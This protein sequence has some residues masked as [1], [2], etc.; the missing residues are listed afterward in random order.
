MTKPSAYP[1]V[2]FPPVA[3]PKTI[4]D[5]HSTVNLAADYLFIQSEPFLRKI[6]RGHEFRTID[7]IN[8]KEATKEEI[9]DGIKND[10]CVSQ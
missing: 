4:T 2:N 7:H 5:L 10:K 8:G 1:T 9:E 6:S 3:I